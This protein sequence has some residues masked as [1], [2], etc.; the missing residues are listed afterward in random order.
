MP[1]NK[2]VMNT[3]PGTINISRSAVGDQSRVTNFTG[4]TT[5]EQALLKSVREH[6]AADPIEREHD[7]F[8]SHATADLALARALHHALEELGADVWVDEFSLGLGQ[9]IARAIDRGIACSRIGVVL[10]TPTVIAGRPWVEKE[11]SALL[12]GKEAVIPI[13]HEVTLEQLHAYSPLL[14]L[15][16][17]L[18]TT[19][20]TVEEIAKLIVSTLNRSR[21]R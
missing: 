16:K 14:H 17:G 19:D 11:F 1:E 20:R 18:N 21:M 4:V 9:N 7:I 2:G 8:L 5:S 3:G 12:D 10:V 6:V 13:L 15:Q